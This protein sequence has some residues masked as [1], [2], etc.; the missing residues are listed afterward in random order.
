MRNRG[1]VVLIED[2]KVGLIRRIREGSIYYVFPG[3][4]IENGETPERTA[5][6]EAFEELGVKVKIKECI[7]KVRFNGTQYFFRAEIMNGVFG[8]GKG[9]EYTDEN[10]ERGTYLPVWIDIETLSSIDVRPKE[11]ALKL[12]N[13]S[14]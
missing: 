10:R 6:R 12:R 7:A 14:E 5:E 13:L 3:G 11:V 8:T 4:G 9:E 2:K 1:S